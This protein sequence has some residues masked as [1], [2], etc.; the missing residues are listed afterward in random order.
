MQR[1]LAHDQNND[2]Y[3]LAR[4]RLAEPSNLS[5]PDRMWLSIYEGL[6][7]DRMERR[8]EALAAYARARDIHAHPMA[9]AG[10]ER[11]LVYLRHLA[12]FEK[13]HARAPR[14][15]PFRGLYE[16]RMSSDVERYG[17][18]T[19]ARIEDRYQVANRE[20][21]TEASRTALEEV[22]RD[23]PDS[24]RAGCGAL[25]LAQW[26]RGAEREARLTAVI[27]DHADA[28]YGDG[29]QVGAYATF[30]LARE[31]KSENERAQLL[32]QL[33]RR[34]PDAIDHS[35]QPLSSRLPRGSQRSPADAQV[36]PPQ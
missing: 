15:R 21:S 20:R 11:P 32:D 6:A 26:A 4:A 29:V 3:L 33:Q 36:A 18:E 8:D 24:N 7:L 25:Y 30:L 12:D 19:A 28:I 23:Y 9:L 1:L 31:T 13:R 27:R 22:I 10:L 2:A 34:W 16:A 35:G 17:R 5:A 14:D